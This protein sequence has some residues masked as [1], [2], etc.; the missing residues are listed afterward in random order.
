[1]RSV[2]REVE[3]KE[4]TPIMRVPVPGIRSPRLLKKIMCQDMKW[5]LFSRVYAVYQERMEVTNEDGYDR[6]SAKLRELVNPEFRDILADNYIEGEITEES[7]RKA[8]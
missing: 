5:K 8:P 6:P 3:T 2:N 1:M 7:L 4:Y